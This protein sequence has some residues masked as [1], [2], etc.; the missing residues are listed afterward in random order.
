MKKTSFACQANDG[1]SAIARLENP[2]TSGYRTG[3]SLHAVN[4]CRGDFLFAVS[5]KWRIEYLKYIDSNI[6]IG[7]VCL[8]INEL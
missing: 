7:A 1:Q 3:L 8:F 6:S 5:L 2:L 4:D